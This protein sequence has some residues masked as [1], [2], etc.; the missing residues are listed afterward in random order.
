MLPTKV[1]ICGCLAVFAQEALAFSVNLLSSARVTNAKAYRGQADNESEITRRTLV[2]WRIS[3]F[4][5]EGRWH[6]AQLTE[7]CLNAHLGLPD[8]LIFL[9]NQK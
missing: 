4:F 1:D 3:A 9:G 8:R 6:S 2:D 7:L 5:E